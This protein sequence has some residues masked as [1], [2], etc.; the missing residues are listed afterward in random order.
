MLS[1]SWVDLF[2]ESEYQSGLRKILKVMS[3]GTFLLRG[4]LKE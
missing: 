3:P 4:E 1:A 2:P